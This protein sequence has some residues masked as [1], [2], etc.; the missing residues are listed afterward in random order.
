MEKGCYPVS[1]D[2]A[3]KQPFC[4]GSAGG[5]VTAFSYSLKPKIG[6]AGV[7]RKKDRRIRKEKKM[8]RLK[9]IKEL[10]HRIGYH[11]QDFN[12]LVMA[13][14]HSSYVNEHHMERLDCN[15]RLEFLG[16]A[17]LEVVSSEFL[18]KN[19]PELPEGELTK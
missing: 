6:Q 4:N 2:C 1:K 19:F 3:G 17:V 7:I 13:M 16:D 9:K 12:L 8:N 5:A 14:R 10:E 11:F 18:Y 15:E